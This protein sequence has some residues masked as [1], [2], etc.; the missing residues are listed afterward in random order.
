MKR[1]PQHSLRAPLARA[2]ALMAVVVLGAGAG[3]SKRDADEAAEETDAEAPPVDASRARAEV[4]ASPVSDGRAEA[5][6]AAVG[7][8]G[9]SCG[10]KNLPDC[11]LQAWMKR[12]ATTMLAFG[13]ISSIADVF[14]Q[15][16][17]LAPSRTFP[18][19][20]AYPYWVSIAQDGAAA[21]RIGDL[22][23]AKA[24]CRGCHEQ[25]RGRY[26]SEFRALAVP[27][28]AVLGTPGAATPAAPQP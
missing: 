27:E 9:R 20:V 15:I 13:D 10:G 3:C 7:I 28:G 6:L 25:Y 11:P 18:G 16:A 17:F 12:Y 21:S 19:A 26:H 24:A 23:A 8:A 4:D 2:L 5:Q 1:A 14:D 22:T